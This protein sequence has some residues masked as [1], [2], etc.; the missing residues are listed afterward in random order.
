M[1]KPRHLTTPKDHNLI[2]DVNLAHEM[3]L[4]GDGERTRAAGLRRVA[5]KVLDSYVE[6][7]NPV[8]SILNETDGN[9]INNDD[10][11]LLKSMMTITE[12]L[13]STVDSKRDFYY[14]PPGNA[15]SIEPTYIAWGRQKVEA[16]VEELHNAALNY[17]KQ[18]GIREDDINL[19][20]RKEFADSLRNGLR[21]KD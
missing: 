8:A 21:A 2:K 14:I 17:D 9:E 10:Y 19:E 11:Q 12:P 1:E 15:V 20:S 18:A 4:A 7:S 16:V 6:G 5:S 3:A 13:Y